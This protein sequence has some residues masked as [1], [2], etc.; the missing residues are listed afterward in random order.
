MSSWDDDGQNP[1]RG[2]KASNYSNP[3]KLPPKVQ[4]PSEEGDLEV[5]FKDYNIIPNYSILVDYFKL[6]NNTY[7]FVDEYSI[8][9]IQL[10]IKYCKICCILSI[11]SYLV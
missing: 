9:H 2:G 8:K 6:K 7:K 3:I 5:F 10:T 11:L 1:I 4:S